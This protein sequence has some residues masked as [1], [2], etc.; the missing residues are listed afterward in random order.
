MVFRCC[1]TLT[2]GNDGG[3]RTVIA[4]GDSVTLVIVDMENVTAIDAAGIGA[5]VAIRERAMRA[6]GRLKLMNVPPRISGLLQLTGLG[7]VFEV[8]SLAD[9]I[10]L[11]CRSERAYE[12]PESAPPLAV[13][14]NRE[15]A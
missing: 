2:A 7:S 4:A 11:I 13:F 9:M 1:G 12:V 3:L 6:G 10:D 14:R 5:L 8:C 15:V